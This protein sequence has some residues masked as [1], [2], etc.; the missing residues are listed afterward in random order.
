MT[1]N[2]EIELAQALDDLQQN[3]NRN[4]HDFYNCASD[5]SNLEYD[6]RT[7]D[8]IIDKVKKNQS[9]AQNL[10]AALCNNVFQRNAV[11]EKLQN[12]IWSCSW[13]QAGGI[14]AM[15]QQQGDYMDWYCSGHR[16]NF[17]DGSVSEGIVTQEIKNDLFAL[18]WLV[19]N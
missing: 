9:Y 17:D 12:Q 10:Y 1:P 19:V 4:E 7:T 2:G 3:L 13:R 11:W 8:W 16:E 5:K 6:L 14:I 15:M 18:G